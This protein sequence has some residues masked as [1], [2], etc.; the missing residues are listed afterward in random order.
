MIYKATQAISAILVLTAA[1]LVLT[2]SSFAAEGGYSN[3]IPGTYGDFGVALEPPGKFTIRNDLYFYSADTS[4]TVRNGQIQVGLDLAMI[5]NMTTMLYKTDCELLGGQYAFGAMVPIVHLGL[6]VEVGSLG[7]Q[8]DVTGF[9]DLVFVPGILYWNRGNMHGSLGQY[10]IAPTADYKLDRLVNPGLNHW[11]FDTNVAFTWL[12]PEKGHEI[13]FNL[14]YIYNT[15]NKATDHQ[16]GQ[17]I[18][19]DLLFNQYLS[20]S[21]AVGIH[22]FYLQQITGDNGDGALLGSFKARSMGIGPAVMWGTKMGEQD[23][24]F[25][26]KWLHE[27]DADHRME[28]DHFFISFALDW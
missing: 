4:Q 27:F 24:T 13:S 19:L 1:E 16:T 14:G 26:A 28:G 11:S 15:E 12:E 6:D 18:H 22:G 25:I 10:V 8:D 5:T 7:A 23:V 21:L 20:E 3:Y 2:P 9:G 17:E